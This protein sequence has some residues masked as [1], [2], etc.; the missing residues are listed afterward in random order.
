MLNVIKTR[1][2]PSSLTDN[3]NNTILK[4]CSTPRRNS[5]ASFEG[6]ITFLFL[7]GSA[8]DTIAII[9]ICIYANLQRV[10]R[11]EPPNSYHTNNYYYRFD[12]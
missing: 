6:K 4:H 7:V 2:H 1:S 5:I 8:V 9:I 11:H 10:R 12:D 3:N